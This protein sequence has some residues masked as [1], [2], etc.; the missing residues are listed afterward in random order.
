MPP[1]YDEAHTGFGGPSVFGAP[2]TPEQVCIF[3]PGASKAGA[4]LQL[5]AAVAAHANV[6]DHDLF[7]GA[8]FDRESKGSTGIGS[9]VAIPHVRT[10]AISRSVLGVGVSA[11]GLDYG[12]VDGKP[13]HL[14]VF[15]ATPAEGNEE[16][17]SLLR[18]VMIA[19]RGTGL[20]SRL[21]ECHTREEVAAALK[22]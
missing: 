3:A 8:V 13:V 10:P 17:L 15:F 19:L 6:S 16:Y 11:A 22:R 4:L 5:V 9:G 2:I 7:R 21:M 20:K 1:A 14:L 12:A 18:Q